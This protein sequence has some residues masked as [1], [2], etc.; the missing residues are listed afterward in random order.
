MLYTLTQNRFGDWAI[1]FHTESGDLF[2]DRQFQTLTEAIAFTL[3][4]DWSIIS[5]VPF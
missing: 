2:P 3:S 1:A 4:P 5:D